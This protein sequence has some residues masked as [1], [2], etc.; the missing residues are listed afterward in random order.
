MFSLTDEE[1]IQHYGRAHEGWTPHS[2]RYEWGSGENA[3]QRRGSFADKVNELKRAGLT[4]KEIATK[5]NLTL[6]EL[7]DKKT[8]DTNA[9]K[10]A[11]AQAIYRIYD[12]G[13]TS[14]TAIGKKL[15]VSESSVRG[16]INR[17]NQNQFDVLTTTKNALKDCVD[18]DTYIDVG[19][20][21]SNYMGVSESRLK[22]AVGALTEDGY[23][24]YRIDIPRTTGGNYIPAKVLC[25]PGVTKGDLMKHMGDIKLP[26]KYTENSATTFQNRE[27]IQNIDSK[28]IYIRYGEEGGVD[29]DGTIELRRGVRDLSL[30]KNNFAQVRI[31]VDDTL[32]LK[33]MAVYRD[34]IP[35]G[36]DI[37]FNTNK[38]RGTPI[39]KVFKPQDGVDEHGV[40]VKPPA[41]P[42]NPF[43]SSLKDDETLM[44]VERHYIDKDGKEKL[45]PI[46]FVKEETDVTSW[47]KTL[48]M[49]FLTKQSTQ[50][51]KKQLDL[52]YKKREEEFEEI[53]ALTNASVK[54]KFMRSFADECD[55]ASVELRGAALPRQSTKILLPSTTIGKNEVYAPTY[56][57]GEEVILVRYPHGGPFEIPRLKVNNNDKDGKM[58]IVNSSGAVAI[59]QKAAQQL[60]GADF[61]GD[62]AVVIPT[63][64]IR[65]TTREPFKS[66]QEFDN[67]EYKIQDIEEGSKYYKGHKIYKNKQGNP[68]LAKNGSCGNEM[69]V[70]TNLITD[71]YA[72]GCTDEELVRAVKYSMVVIDAYKHG[73]DYY[74][75]RDDFAITALK[76]K[77]QA[78]PGKSKGGGASTL[79]TRIGGQME[80]DKR[81]S[82]YKID[83]ETGEAVYETETN[84]SRNTRNAPAKYRVNPETGK[85]E[86]VE[87]KKVAKTTKTKKGLEYDPYEL[88]SDNPTEME[89]IYADHARQCK[90]L[91][92]KARLES[93]KAS[94]S[95]ME[96]NADA[97]KTY[98]K[99][100]EHLKAQLEVAARNSPLERRANLLANKYV[101]LRKYENPD[102]KS[103]TDAVKKIRNKAISDARLQVGA[104]KTLVEIS[105]KEWEAIQA[106][107]LYKSTVDKIIENTDETKLKALAMPRPKKEYS[108]TT[109]EQVKLMDERGYTMSQIADKL[110]LSS[111]GV[112]EILS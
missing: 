77:Y 74:Q 35:D 19:K 40:R 63:K 49:Q 41:D 25:S 70:A 79:F 68:T 78:Q 65:I 107:A 62:T 1:Y 66:L 9:E 90:A 80:V 97:A 43:G 51:A 61:D 69:G 108:S 28:R 85:K 11:R 3:K 76:N 32:Y 23:N 21:V 91:A 34:D 4:E 42:S 93:L 109:I 13:I 6:Q 92:N 56:K 47:K 36:Y 45:S 88:M 71:M 22:S 31:G 103:D 50:L 53:N 89:I 46:N 111:E 83:P 33:G 39:N 16:F 24:V 72:K 59:S 12:S 60:S 94:N 14:P 96:R 7:R 18:K 99:E 105:D 17:R 67:K 55:T 52:D 64:N 2:G 30:G 20:G 110:G 38:K 57:Q 26:F 29:R 58:T 86:V 75:A 112:S 106:G 27:P 37:V 87:W 84:P 10:Q 54:A 81:K 98:E 8:A 44:S 101:D 48:P 104:N 5:F 82:Y 100:V 73:L 95:K 102:L 15:G